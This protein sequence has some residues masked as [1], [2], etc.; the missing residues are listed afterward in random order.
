MALFSDKQKRSR[1]TS[2][3][4][5]PTDPPDSAAL[6]AAFEKEAPAGAQKSRA[7]VFVN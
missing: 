7:R 1:K 3:G 6:E 4:T 2:L 5:K